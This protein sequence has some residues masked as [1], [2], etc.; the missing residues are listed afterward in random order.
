MDFFF[1]T[2]MWILI[3]D[4]ITKKLVAV[5]LIHSSGWRADGTDVVEIAKKLVMMVKNRRKTEKTINISRIIR[6]FF[7]CVLVSLVTNYNII[8]QEQGN[9]WLYIYIN[10]RIFIGLLSVAIERPN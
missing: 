2:N 3:F 10:F 6:L 8:M 1:G 7:V 9:R 4:F 5:Y